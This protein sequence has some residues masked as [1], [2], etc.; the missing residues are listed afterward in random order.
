MRTIEEVTSEG[1]GL[2]ATVRDKYGAAARQ[3]AA[4]QRATCAPSGSMASSG[5][6]CGLTTAADPVTRDL[7]SEV[8]TGALPEAAVLASLGCGNPTASGGTP[9]GRSRARPRIG[10]WHRRAPFGSPGRTQRKGLRPRHDR[11]HARVGAQQPGRGRR[12]ERRVPQG[13]HR[14][15]PASG[16]QRRRHHLQLR[17]QSLG[18]QASRARRGLPRAEAGRSARRLRHRRAR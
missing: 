13:S 16:R 11:R 15:H 8:E 2:R 17:H 5:C 3:A 12:R 18:G 1:D 7:Y 6:G 10:R 14:G 4:G 9:R